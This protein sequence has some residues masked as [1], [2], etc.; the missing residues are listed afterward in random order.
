MIAESLFVFWYWESLTSWLIRTTPQS[1][2]DVDRFFG[3]NA[4]LRQPS[5][6]IRRFECE[7]NALLET[8]T[9]HPL[10]LAHSHS[11]STLLSW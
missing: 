10:S 4:T 2:E 11:H 7:V 1:L 8:D 9:L 6:V 5:D 3:L